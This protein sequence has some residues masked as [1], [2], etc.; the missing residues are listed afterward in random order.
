MNT[1]YIL[2]QTDFGVGGGAS[3]YGMCK[4]VDARLRSGELSHTVPTFDVAEASR[5]LGRILPYWPEGTAFV[6][7]VDPG[8]G[9]KRRACVAKTI[10][11]YYITTPDN[12]TL[13][14]IYRSQ[15]ITE[16]RE[17]DETVNRYPH[18]PKVSI[19]HGRDLFAYCAARLASG[20]ISWE[21]VGPAYSTEEIVLLEDEAA[22]K[23]QA[24]NV[25]EHADSAMQGGI[26]AG[27]SASKVIGVYTYHTK[28][29][30]DDSESRRKHPAPVA[31]VNDFNHDGRLALMR[32]IA[33]RFNPKAEVYDLNLRPD[34][35]EQAG[36]VIAQNLRCW[37]EGTV[38]VMAAGITASTKVVYARTA[39]NRILV[40]SDNGFVE[41]VTG[42][43]GLSGKVYY[44]GTDSDLPATGGGRTMP[45]DMMMPVWLAVCAAA[46]A[47]K[48]GV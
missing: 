11:G 17:I 33:K 45:E 28:T 24:A 6:S 3:M 31:V 39:D 19:F 2:F 41:R 29:S 26:Y 30:A 7:V 25:Y 8:V 13:S 4:L 40:A 12:G 46:L 44:A 16:I 1:P 21:E 36:E 23:M 48:S 43:C 10:N 5:R 37:P 18:T 32:G 27:A 9:T 38:F 35:T 15:G 47:E 20:Q 34:T 14:D 42:L 22:N